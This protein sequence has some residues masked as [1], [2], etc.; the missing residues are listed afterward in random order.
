MALKILWCSPLPPVRSGVS[1]YA[2][3]LL[4]PLCQR[5]Q[6]RILSPSGLPDPQIPED[7]AVAIVPPDTEP[8]DG[9]IALVHLGNNPHHC[10]LVDRCA[11][12]AP[13]IVVHDLVLHHL[14]VEYSA[15]IGDPRILEQYLRLGHNDAGV[16]LAKAREYGLRGRL[17]PFMFPARRGLLEGARALVTHSRWGEKILRQEF[18][19]KPVLRL[20][21]AAVDPFPVDR[22]S[23]RKDL[24]VGN[25][26][27]LLMHL[28]FLTQE[29]GLESVLAAVAAAR[30]CGVSVRVVLVGE[31]DGAGRLDRAVAACGLEEVV[32]CTGWV[33]WEHMIR[34]PA[35]ADLGIVLRV[36]SAGETSAAVV[37]FLACGTPVAVVGQRQFLEWPEVAAPRITPGPSAQAEVTRLLIGAARDREWGSRRAAARTTYTN[38]H[39]PDDI[40]TNLVDFLSSL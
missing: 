31:R 1:D 9:E 34:M 35:A 24:G 19:T 5:A 25:D 20:G 10:W 4:R 37:R 13:V 28:G 40:A 14:I 7:L 32:T 18:P 26:E 3:E 8:F 36:P 6:V 12:D 17:D 27:L 22:T 30:E 15:T 39:R 33:E 21:L 2:V 38:Q 23:L 16:A 11:R 29:K